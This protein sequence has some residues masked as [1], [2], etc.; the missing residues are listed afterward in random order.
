MH[1]VYRKW[2]G[3]ARK[4]PLNLARPEH[5]KFL[6]H[7]AHVRRKRQ[8]DLAELAGEKSFMRLSPIGQAAVAFALQVGVARG[9][10]PEGENAYA[11]GPDDAHRFIPAVEYD[12]Q[13]AGAGEGRGEAELSRQ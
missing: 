13:V 9:N 10:L 5:F 6:A 8:A 4:K 2:R 3:F 7:H 12:A 11:G 1:S